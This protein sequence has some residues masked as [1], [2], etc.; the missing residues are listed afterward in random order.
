VIAGGLYFLPIRAYNERMTN[1]FSEDQSG[2][3]VTVSSVI[4]AIKRGCAAEF[5]AGRSLVEMDP[6]YPDALIEVT[7]DGRRF[8]VELEGADGARTLRRIS[9]IGPKKR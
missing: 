9:E 5:A 6:L 8:I 1:G 4:E 2:S 3:L 7:P